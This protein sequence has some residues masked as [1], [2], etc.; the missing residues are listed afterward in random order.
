MK[1]SLLSALFAFALMFTPIDTHAA[2]SC[3]YSEQA[4]LNAIVA[5]VKA[6]YEIVDIYDGMTTRLDYEGEPEI[7]S[8]VKGFNINILNIAEDIYV[9]IKDSSGL[10]EQTLRYSDTQD[11]IAT[12]QTK[13]VDE[14]I[15]YTI[16]IYS[17]KYSCIGEKFRTITFQTP[18]YNN[19]SQMGACV[20]NPGFYYC[21][22]VISTNLISI[23][24]FMKKLEDYRQDKTEE[25][26]QEEKSKSFFEKLKEFYE[27]NKSIIYTTIIFI[28]IIG[29]TTIVILVRKRRRRVL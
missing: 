14:L 9:T 17:N 12:I 15:N 8:Y 18:I 23:N 2:S 25:Q 5:N 13:N 20:E 27:N 3:S 11:G 1:K 19:F 21:Q 7:E 16:E 28:L 4:E 22:E 29:G 24:E 6:T 10:I 26:K